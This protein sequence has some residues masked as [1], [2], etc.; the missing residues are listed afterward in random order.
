MYLSRIQLNPQNRHTM[1]A[2]VN[3]QKIHG[4][5]EASFPGERKRRLWRIDVLNDRTYLLVC[6]ADQPD[7]TG[8]A[9]QYGMPDAPWETRKY[10]TFLER[11]QT[12][13]EWQFRLTANPVV[14]KKQAGADRGK[15]LAHVTVDQQEAWL[16]ERAVSHG[17]ALVPG[18]YRVT[19]S[20]WHRFAK[21]GAENRVMLHAVTFEGRLRVTD[22]ERFRQTLTGGLGHGKAYGMGMLTV[23]AETTN[24]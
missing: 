1:V 16:L 10:D 21:C 20:T 24:A 12:G 9:G 4:A 5:V 11:I 17:F 8:L 6:S 22:A 14:A 2:L 19:N 23:A 15:K 18:E 3:P 7:F 13:S